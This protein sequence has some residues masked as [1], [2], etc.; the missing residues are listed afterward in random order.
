MTHANP[1]SPPPPKDRVALEQESIQ[2][3]NERAARFADAL[4]AAQEAAK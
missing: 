3:A 1:D 2:R 4:K